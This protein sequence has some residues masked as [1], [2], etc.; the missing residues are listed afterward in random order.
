MEEIQAISGCWVDKKRETLAVYFSWSK[1]LNPEPDPEG[2]G[3]RSEMDKY[4]NQD[5]KKVSYVVCLDTKL[6]LS[7]FSLKL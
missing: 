7:I 4:N 3:G 1:D 2:A 5:S 6:I